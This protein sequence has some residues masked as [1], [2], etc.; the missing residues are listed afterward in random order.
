LYKNPPYIQ[1]K[2]DT[3]F[4]YYF[5]TF[6]ISIHSGCTMYKNSSLHLWLLEN[7]EESDE[8]LEKA[9]KK[10]EELLPKI[11]KSYEKI[12]INFIN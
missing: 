7:V 4:G 6:L 2:Q 3:I 8:N 11:K 9:L 1:E 12:G 5:A 10:A